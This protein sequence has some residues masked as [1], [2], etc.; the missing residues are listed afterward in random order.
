MNPLFIITYIVFVV[1]I[2]VMPLYFFNSNLKY[3]IIRQQQTHI[4][5]KYGELNQK[6]NEYSSELKDKI[7]V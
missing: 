3:E 2:Y 5:E 7:K 1:I 4:F 6:Y